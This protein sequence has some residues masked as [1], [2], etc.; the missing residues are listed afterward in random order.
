MR[1]HGRG[2]FQYFYGM[3]RLTVESKFDSLLVVNELYEI[4]LS[5]RRCYGYHHGSFVLILAG[6]RLA[7]AFGG[8]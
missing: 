8:S 2:N 5:L 7:D 1:K 3:H 6:A 4:L